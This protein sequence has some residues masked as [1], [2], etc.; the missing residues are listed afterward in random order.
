MHSAFIPL[1]G[2]CKDWADQSGE[3][4][5]DVVS[6]LCA[7]IRDQQFS[8][9]AFKHKPTGHYLGARAFDHVPSQ[10]TSSIDAEQ[11]DA[12]KALAEIVVSTEEI[13]EFCKKTNTRPPPS[14]TR[15]GGRFQWTGK[16]YLAPPSEANQDLNR[17]ERPRI[18]GTTSD[19]FLPNYIKYGFIWPLGHGL[20]KPWRKFN[21]R[22]WAI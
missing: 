15:T 10:I 14:A 2:L 17:G 4:I 19:A 22:F 16:K 1:D 20:I 12:L 11:R 3:P 13:F 6:N 7:H 8:P 21:V 5:A 9:W 18:M